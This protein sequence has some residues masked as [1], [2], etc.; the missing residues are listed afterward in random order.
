ML[1]VKREAGEQ[2]KEERYVCYALCRPCDQMRS[3]VRISFC[4]KRRRDDAECDGGDDV[5]R[6]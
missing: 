6:R 1:I 4:S 3:N 5:G 2:V